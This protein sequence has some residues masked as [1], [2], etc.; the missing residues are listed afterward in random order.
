MRIGACARGTAS[1]AGAAG[2]RRL[3][4]TRA[5]RST[6]TDIERQMAQAGLASSSS[7]AVSSI[8]QKIAFL[9]SLDVLSVPATYDEPKG[10]F[11][12]EA[13]ATGVP[14]VQPRRGAFPEIIEKTGGGILVDAGDPE[15]LAQGCSRTCGAIR[16]GVLRSARPGPQVCGPITRSARWRRQSNGSTA[17]C[18]VVRTAAVA[19]RPASAAVN[20]RH[21]HS[22]GHHEVVPDTARRAPD[23]ERRFRLTLN[24]AMRSPSRGRP[25]AVRARCSTSSAR[26]SLPR[27]AR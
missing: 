26:S 1:D 4:R 13:M 7:I 27:P 5:P 2:R 18:S 11:L 22:D 23:P 20:G 15:A 17:R 25:A 8:A 16:Q 21:A 3:S 12:F 9:Q 6:S 14:V 10:M 24:A 19:G